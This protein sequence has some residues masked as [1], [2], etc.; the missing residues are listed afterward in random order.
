MAAQSRLMETVFDFEQTPPLSV[1]YRFFLS[2]PLF[3]AAAGLLLAWLGPEAFASRWSPGLLAVVHLL[4]VGFMLQAMAGALLQILPV[5][6]GANVWRP[7]F[8]ARCAHVGLGLGA[9]CLAGGFLF[10]IPL[11]FRG[12]MLLL[13]ATVAGYALVVGLSLTRTAARGATVV[14]MRLSI[15]ALLPTL[16]LGEFLAG[17]FGWQLNLPLMDLVQLHAAWAFVGW[18]LLLVMGVAYLVVPMFQL[19]PPYRPPVSTALPVAQFSLLLAWSALVLA[20][21]PHKMPALLMALPVAGFAVLTLVLQQRRRRRLPDVTLLFWRV[22]MLALIGAVLA[23][24]VDVLLPEAG[25]R[26]EILAGVLLIPGVFVSLI[27]GMLYKIMPFLNWLHLQ[28]VAPP[29]PNMKHM[30]GEAAMTR[31]FRL[32]LLSLL[33]ALAAVFLPVL[34]RPAGLLLAASALYLEWNLLGVARIYRR[35]VAGEPAVQVIRKLPVASLK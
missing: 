19:T 18:G 30:L 23:V 20:D 34:V 1:P 7:L 6:A 11:L 14:A 9:L 16:V 3:A 2:A 21:L 8:V 17:A 24:A 4:T 26:L 28:R 12:A 22:G 27:S 33:V 29:A 31:Q 10:G 13:G 32:H 5:A 25:A 15:L 35:L